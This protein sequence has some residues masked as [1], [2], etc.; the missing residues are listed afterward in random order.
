[1][2]K[3]NGLLII[4]VAFIAGAGGFFAGTK[5]QQSRNPASSRQFPGGQGIRNNFGQ[6]SRQG[7]RPVSGEIIS[8]DE[9]SMTVKLLDG[10]SKIVIFSSQMM[11]NKAAEGTIDD[12]KVGE[13]ISVF[14]TD[15]TD[16]SITA[17]NIQLG[18][19]FRGEPTPT[20]VK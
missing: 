20:V 13:R 18:Q 16:G 6:G 3:N 14:G 5:Y 19:M 1:M 12:L 4:L 17:Q 7:F 9:K 11:I 15:N 2:K 10:S 8:T